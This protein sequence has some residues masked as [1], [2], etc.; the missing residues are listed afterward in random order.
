MGASLQIRGV[1][2][3]TSFGTT[4]HTGYDA[5]AL[6]YFQFGHSTFL[7]GTDDFESEVAI[8]EARAHP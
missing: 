5:N 4:A 6:M 7:C 8:L 1:N 2:L 3:K